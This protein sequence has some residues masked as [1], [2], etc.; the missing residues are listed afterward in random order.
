MLSITDPSLWK[1]VPNE[2]VV[3]LTSS[4]TPIL[5]VAVILIGKQEAEE[6][7][8][9]EHNITGIDSFQNNLTLF[10]EIFAIIE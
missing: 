8:L 10:P 5:L 6:Q 1:L 3:L 2:I 4:E 7:V 9:N